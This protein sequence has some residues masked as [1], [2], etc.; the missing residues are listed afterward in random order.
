MKLSHSKL[1]TILSCPMSYYLSYIEGISTIDEKPA[2]W[3]GS[4]VHW[5]IE[6]NTEDLTEYF[7]SE[8]KNYSREQLLAESMVHGYL[9][10]KD[11]IMNDILTMPDGSKLTLVDESHELY[12]NGKL[13]SFK[14]EDGHTFVGIIDL[15]LLT[16]KG[17]IIIDYKTS[18]YTPDWNNYLE[19]I[20]RYMFLVKSEF[21]DIPIVKIGIINIRKTAIRQKKTE[22]LQQ[23][24]NRMKFEY[25]IN[26]ENYVN[27]HEYNPSEIEHKVIDNYI[28]NL[29]KMSDTA[30]MID[31][32]KMWFINYG[33]ANGQYGKSDYWNIFYRIPDSYILYKI[34]DKIVTTDVDNNIIVAETRPCRPL[35]MLVIDN[36]N[37]LNHYETYKSEWENF[38]DTV[39]C[40]HTMLREKYICDDDL[41]EQYRDNVS[42]GF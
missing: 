19:Q 3:I 10:H 25:E 32:N 33:A 28:S 13:P 38:T 11:E 14:Y 8:Q 9:K 36:N 21:P 42:L 30:A 23:F 39:E 12:V 26:D 34:R 18:T 24:L 40:F 17:F 6:H 35:D 20:Y 5:G 2:L 31:E 7:K 27:Y 15:L 4:A 1:S 29:S 16:D 37:V 22:N 41:L